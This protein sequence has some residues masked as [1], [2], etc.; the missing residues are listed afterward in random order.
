MEQELCEYTPSEDRKDACRVDMVVS[1]HP[2]SFTWK[3]NM[4]LTEHH[5]CGGDRPP[6]PHLG[7][8]TPRF[9]RHSA[10]EETVVVTMLRHVPSGQELAHHYRHE[11]DC[12]FKAGAVI[13]WF[14]MTMDEEQAEWDN[15]SWHF[16]RKII[17]RGK[18][19]AV[20]ITYQSSPMFSTRCPKDLRRVHT[21]PKFQSPAVLRTRNRRTSACPCRVCQTRWRTCRIR[22]SRR[23]LDRSF[24]TLS[25]AA[26][27]P[28]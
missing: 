13:D 2:R 22:E 21:I 4:K 9:T 8:C 25:P 17:R 23:K 5:L 26:E 28:R 10:N 14:W 12:V 7:H 11:C 6:R 19:N 20:N 27:Y 16:G 1:I 15:G 18:E 3:I 24:A